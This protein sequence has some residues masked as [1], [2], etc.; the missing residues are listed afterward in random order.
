MFSETNETSHKL[1]GVGKKTHD[2][3][4]RELE[5]ISLKSAY[6]DECFSNRRRNMENHDSWTIYHQ[7][8]ANDAEPKQW[9]W[10]SINTETESFPTNKMSQ[11]CA[12]FVHICCSV[13]FIKLLFLF[14]MFIFSISVM[15]F[16]YCTVYTL[17]SWCFSKCIV[18]NSYCRRI[19]IIFTVSINTVYCCGR[20]CCVGSSEGLM[21]KHV[22]H[23]SPSVPLLKKVKGKTDKSAAAF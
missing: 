16:C 18:I 12:V 11:S 21:Q 7:K 23:F 22:A 5:R 6:I 10:F 3:P 19:W 8:H 17:I 9:K 1:F 14:F 20:V 2:C 15:C 13:S 4:I